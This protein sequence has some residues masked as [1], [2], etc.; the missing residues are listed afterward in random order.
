[1]KVSALI[2]TR[3]RPNELLKCLDSVRKQTKQPKEILILDNGSDDT[4]SLDS[5]KINLDNCIVYKTDN[6]L[7]CPGGRNFLIKK[8]NCELLL[9][10]DDD[11]ILDENAIRNGINYFKEIIDLAVVTFRI[12]DPKDGKI[13]DGIKKDEKPFFHHTFGGGSCIIK[14]KVLDDTGLYP[15][16][17]LRQ[18]EESD[19]AIRIIN[20]GYKI[21]YAPDCIL[22]H[23]EVKNDILD[24]FL[25]S[26]LSTIS[27]S[28]K[29]LPF[30]YAIARTII[31]YKRLKRYLKNQGFD[32]DIKKEIYMVIKNSIKSRK[33]IKYKSYIRWFILLIKVKL[34]FNK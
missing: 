29:Y 32:L 23:D 6:N 1:M 10:V 13:R 20:S 17:F 27:T 5:Y 28:W 16:E 11:G 3:N 15:T 12:I 8:S 33:R 18:G 19:L 34:K 22:Y 24:I 31:N 30:H 7:G 9:F 14:K 4:L 21:I 2:L 26:Q 25:N